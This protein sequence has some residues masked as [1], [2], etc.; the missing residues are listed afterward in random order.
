LLKILYLVPNLGD[1][2]V[3]R[4]IRM[5]QLGGAKV[6]IAGFRRADAPRPDL[7]VDAMVELDVTHD[8]RFAQR[9]AAT[10]RASLAARNW[11]KGL[12]RPDVI[13]ARSLEMLAVGNRVRQLWGAQPALAYESLDIHRLLLRE[14]AIG[15]SMR[16][17]ERALAAQAGLLITS[18][19]AFLANYFA[20]QGGPPAMLVE[21]KVLDDG[22]ERGRNPALA[23][24]ADKPFRVGWFGALRCRKSLA[25]LTALSEKLGGEVEVVLRGR[26][27]L[28]EFDDFHGSVQSASHLQYVGPYRNPQ[29]MAAIYSGVHFAWAI[30]FFEEG[31][32]SRWL[33]PNRIYEGC[34]HG[35]VPL[36]LAGTETAAFIERLGIGVVLAD[37]APSTLEGFFRGLTVEGVAEL[38][39]AVAACPASHFRTNRAECQ[40]LVERLEGL[41][42]PQA[43]L[44]EAAA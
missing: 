33:L 17:A 30:D 11:T 32:N 2:A 7:P 29:D 5:L 37:I 35:A 23:A 4:R 9:L 19:P 43:P 15:Q 20:L 25:A 12:S 10:L 36:A 8:A 13:I 40:Q 3:E 44:L 39:R 38:A 6:E 24:D 18:S 26:P 14:D 34:L 28:T 42:S 27:A 31:Q 41:R 1:A 21:N 16:A 22:E